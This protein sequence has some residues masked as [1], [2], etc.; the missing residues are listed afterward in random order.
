MAKKSKIKKRGGVIYPQV[1]DIV[2]PI[3]GEFGLA[4]EAIKRIPEAMG[5]IDREKYRVFVLDNGTPNW[6]TNDGQLISAE[7]MAEPVKEQLGSPD[8]F[9]RV[10][11][12]RGYPSGMNNLVI[13]GRSPLVLLLTPDVLMNPGSIETMVMGMDDPD[14]GVIGPK[15]LFPED[16]EQSPHGP[17]GKT[18]HAGLAFNIRGNP[19]HI[20]LTWSPE[21][22]KVHRRREMSAVTGAC[23]ITRRNLWNEIGGF[24]LEYGGGTYEDVDYCF[25]I[26]S[27]GKKVIFEPEAEGYHMVGGSMV[28]GANQGGFN[29]PM[30]STIFKGRW[31]HMLA[32]DEWRYL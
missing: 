13:Q 3:F 27:M 26:R 19:Y 32:W 24:P 7:E 9:S 1:L 14:V 10:D 16:A 5:D 20:F 25:A 31:A 18:Q 23:F 2:M 12:N 6:E 21:H 30:N 29:L 28:Q 15:L 8:K 22:P 4:V 17:P 11:Q